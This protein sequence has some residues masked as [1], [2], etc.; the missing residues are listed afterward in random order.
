M[1]NIDHV[2][3]SVFRQI[4]PRLFLVS[5]I[6]VAQMKRASRHEKQLTVVCSRWFTCTYLFLASSGRGNSN[7]LDDN[8]FAH[9]DHVEYP[10]RKS[11]TN[12]VNCSS[13]TRDTLF[14]TPDATIRFAKFAF[15][16]GSTIFRDDRRTELFFNI[17]GGEKR[18]RVT[19][20]VRSSFETRT[21]TSITFP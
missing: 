8:D 1:S 4:A 14:D 6:K 3:P 2:S 16:D 7:L 19:L 18:I 13:K 15:G 17:P 21:V 9:D 5:R 20:K 11:N 12:T 10:T